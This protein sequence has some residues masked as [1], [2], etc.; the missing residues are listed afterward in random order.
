VK[1]G[2]DVFLSYW[3]ADSKVAAGLKDQLAEIFGDDH[4]RNTAYDEDVSWPL[5]QVERVF[6]ASAVM[7]VLIGRDWANFTDQRGNRPDEPA[8][9]HLRNELLQA[10]RLNLLIV[11]VCIDGAAMPDRD[12]LPVFLRPLAGFRPKRLRTADLDTDKRTFRGDARALARGI[13]AEWRRR[14]GL[15]PQWVIGLACAAAIIAA[16]AAGAW[17]SVL[18]DSLGL[19]LPPAGRL[20]AVDDKQQALWQ[21]LGAAEK[22]RDES[23]GEAAAMRDQLAR[24]SQQL[25]AAERERDDARRKVVTL[26]ERRDQLA[27]A[28]KERD[29]AGQ[30]SGQSVTALRERLAERREIALTIDNVPSQYD[31][32]VVLRL[33]LSAL[34]GGMPTD[35][36]GIRQEP[37]TAGRTRAVVLT[38][39]STAVDLA[40]A[41]QRVDCQASSC[42]LNVALRPWYVDSRAGDREEPRFI[43]G[44]RLRGERVD[45]FLGRLGVKDVY[46][47]R[48]TQSGYALVYLPNDSYFQIFLRGAFGERAPFVDIRGGDYNL[49][50]LEGAAQ[51]WSIRPDYD[52]SLPVVGDR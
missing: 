32:K 2:F 9:S 40:V 33:V 29:E 50:R 15:A 31:E 52:P 7:V 30:E 28:G 18:L 42:M 46:L 38:V 49:L 16:V 12:Q 1:A 24:L 37:A 47:P 10:F 11:P 14:Q 5:T 44:T 3:P 8:N 34:R 20:R 27:A 4:V 51:H 21:R 13:N 39:N 45:A 35:V 19:P 25:T 43:A 22:E 17:G 26:Y 23:R 41:G 48:I 36:V 6:P